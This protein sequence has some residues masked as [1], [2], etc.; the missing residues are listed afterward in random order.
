MPLRPGT[1][2]RRHLIRGI[3]LLGLLLWAG[4]TA[5][6]A[7]LKPLPPGLSFTGP[8]HAVAANDIRL[9][10]D[11]TRPGPD[12]PVIQQTLFDEA[13][14]LIGAAEQLVVADLFLFNAYL[15]KATDTH[16]ALSTEIAAALIARQRQ[17]PGMAVIVI[18]DPVNEAYG[19]AEAPALRALREAG[20]PVVLTRL[21]RLRDSNPLW[22]GFWRLALRPFGVSPG[23]FMPHPFAADAPGV[24]LRSWFTL[25][26]F[27]ANHR[28]V[29]IADALGADADA[30]EL[31]ALVMSAN[32]HDGSSAH[33]NVA[34]AVRGAVVHDL[35]RSEQAVLA[36]S[37]HEAWPSPSALPPPPP[38]TAESDAH[39][40]V[41]TEGRIR[42]AVLEA[43]DRA[44]PDD[45][46]D[47]A[48]FYLSERRIITALK[49]AAARG[50][51]V[52]L[53]LDPNRDAFGYAKDGVPNKPVAAELVAAHPG[54]AVRWYDTRGEQFHSKLLLVRHSKRAT[55]LAGSANFTRRN[56]ANLNL[57]TN[58]TLEAPLDFPAI[59][60]ATAY[61]EDLWHNRHGPATLPYAE[62]ADASRLRY[63]KYRLQEATGLGTF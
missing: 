17:H 11:V 53:L 37:D 46:V 22:S 13:L 58:L 26:N 27:K 51:A 44:G 38:L 41:I 7:W 3:L 39:V 63:G 23:G 54:I 40:R 1:S 20:I 45:R 47:L 33:G 43:L 42:E 57:E 49:G 55:L 52:R 48:M 12:G 9:L 21:D 61:F 30:R 10:V 18:T 59:A 62:G 60:D 14:R 29:I 34:L 8:A 56:L 24:G 25:L 31:V 16:R 19:G 28:K 15:G 32:P 2:P 5:Y 4:V 36:L 6:H 35:L 50:A